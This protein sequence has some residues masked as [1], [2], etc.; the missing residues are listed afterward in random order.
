MYYEIKASETIG[1]RFDGVY[2]GLEWFLDKLPLNKLTIKMG[3]STVLHKGKFVWRMSEKPLESIFGLII[4]N[5]IKVTADM[6][7]MRY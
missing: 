1:L 7:S 3:S 2:L 4:V 5:K 6:C